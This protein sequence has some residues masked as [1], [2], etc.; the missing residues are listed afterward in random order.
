MIYR[1]I[2]Y[3]KGVISGF[4]EASGKIPAGFNAVI[5]SSI[6]VGAGL[7]SSAALEVATLTFLE[8]F[9]DCQIEKLVVLRL[10]EL[11]YC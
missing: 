5:V 11:I 8:H 3:V 9:N 10:F 1:W 4:T 2:N 7:S 6:P